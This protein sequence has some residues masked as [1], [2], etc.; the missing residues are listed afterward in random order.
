MEARKVIV[1]EDNLLELVSKCKKCGANVESRDITKRYEGTALILVYTCTKGCIVRWD[2][3]PRI[4][5]RFVL[6][7]LLVSAAYFSAISISVIIR[8]L[9]FINVACPSKTTFYRVIG[10]YCS[11]AI[12]NVWQREQ[13][14]LI[15]DRLGKDLDL[16]GDQ[17]CDSPGHSGECMFCCLF[18]FWFS[19]ERCF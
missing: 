14:L 11:P 16:G 17:R 13:T 7:I 2:S 1:F 6:N 12:R 19:I 18:V 15:Q 5:N 10:S 4:A 9:K 8:M 3:Q